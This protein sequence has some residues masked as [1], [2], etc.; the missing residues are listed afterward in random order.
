MADSFVNKVNVW[1][2]LSLLS[3]TVPRYLYP[4]SLST[5]MPSLKRSV[6]TVGAFLKSVSICLVFFTFKSR[7]L[8]MHQLLNLSASTKQTE[9]ELERS[10][11]AESSEYFVS[12]VVSVPVQSFV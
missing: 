7:E 1:I 4:D 5:F 6:M 11:I 12:G 9:S 10:S 2:K 3:K 8:S